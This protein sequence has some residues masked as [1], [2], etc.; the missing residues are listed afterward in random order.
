MA[1][2]TNPENPSSLTLSN[3]SCIHPVEF[4]FDATV[5]LIHQCMLVD[6]KSNY[7]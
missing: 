4:E 5:M 1:Y 6:D 3:V 7:R 2:A